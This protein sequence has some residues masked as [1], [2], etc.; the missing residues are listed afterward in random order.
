MLI[1]GGLNH[2]IYILQLKMLVGVGRWGEIEMKLLN[3]I[4][5][6]G[7]VKPKQTFLGLKQQE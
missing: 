5:S 7:G 1:Y 6:R 3:V 2:I 4:S